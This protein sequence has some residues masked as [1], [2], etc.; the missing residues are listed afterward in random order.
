MRN[1]R[2]LLLVLGLIVSGSYAASGHAELV[3]SFPKSN[4]VITKSPRYVQL[5]FAEDLAALRSKSSNSITVID[6]KA[7]KIAA[8][9]IKIK[10]SVA[11][12][13][14]LENLKPGKYLVKYRIVSADGHVLNSQ[15]SFTLS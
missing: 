14:L 15:F 10:N 5:E 8:S 12:I 9:K 11:R 2:I 4:S 13:E 1:R 7:H 6:L 3:K